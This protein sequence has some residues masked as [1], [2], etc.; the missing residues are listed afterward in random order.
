MGPE[1]W[2]ELAGLINQME[3]SSIVVLCDE[4]TGTACLPVLKENLALPEGT[5]F[6]T[7]PAGET[8][9]QIATCL[10]LWEQL[11]EL[12]ID[13]SGL[14][15]NLGGGVVTDLGGF[16]ASTYKRGIRF[17][18]IPTSLLAMVDASIGGK[19]GVDLGLLKNQV[20]VIR[21]PE[22]V[23]VDATFLDSLPEVEFNS[24]KAEMIK[25]GLIRDKD[26]L[27]DV[28]SF[29]PGQKARAS[30]LIGGSIAIKQAIVQED[31]F[32][33]GIRKSLNFG[34][35]LGHAIESY[36]LDNDHVPSLLHGEAIAI[37]MILESYLSHLSLGF[38]KSDLEKVAGELVVRY[39]KV[40]FQ[41][42]DVTAIA[43]LMKYD[44]KNR[45][46]RIRFVLLAGIGRPSL[47]H[48]VPAQWIYQA[49]EFYE[50]LI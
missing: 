35:T 30:E 48:E 12:G 44:K 50:K 10:E 16:V 11:A 6:L 1:C 28:L 7:I 5:H 4:N 21:E 18:N 27:Q 32:E 47:D 41:E 9:K 25:H 17:V 33:K 42:K 31:P 43:D 45:G 2:N 40:L 26:Y 14:M 36:C 15:I 22:Q 39:P 13:R 3:P 46:G 19:N 8:Y 20:G 24:G 49:F 29:E 37:G 23:L 38:S 34:H